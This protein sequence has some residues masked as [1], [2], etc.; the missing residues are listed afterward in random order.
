MSG[1]RMRVLLIALSFVLFGVLSGMVIRRQSIAH[2]QSVGIRKAILGHPV[3]VVLKEYIGC[4]ST[5]D[6]TDKQKKIVLARRGDGAT[7]DIRENFEGSDSTVHLNYASGE[8]VLARKRL[9]IG[10]KITVPNAA[11]LGLDPLTEC[12][13]GLGGGRSEMTKAGEEMISG[14]RTIKMAKDSPST[15]WEIWYSPDLGCT[16]CVFRAMP[17]SVP[18]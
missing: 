11:N 8:H 10:A 12:T 1:K 2:A 18:N 15:L 6:R 13:V 17:I 14:Y 7:A 4:V 16:M 9:N 3:T 5:N